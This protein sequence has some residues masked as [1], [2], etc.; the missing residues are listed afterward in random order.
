MY[1]VFVCIFLLAS[2]TRFAIAETLLNHEILN[3]YV[4]TDSPKNWFSYISALLHNYLKF[5]LAQQ[6]KGQK[7]SYFTKSVKKLMNRI[8][9]IRMLS[10]TTQITTTQYK[11]FSSATVII[12]LGRAM[13]QDF[14]DILHDGSN[15]CFK[16]GFDEY[17][18]HIHTWIFALDRQ[19][20]LNIT[21]THIR[22]VIS[23]L[24]TCYIGNVTVGTFDPSKNSKFKFVYCGILSNIPNYP[25]MRN[26]DIMVSIR[27]YVQ[28]IVVFSYGVIDPDRT[29][30]L[31]PQIDK[32]INPQ[33][34]LH[35]PTAKKYLQFV[36]L[37]VEKYNVI[38]LSF[39]KFIHSLY[40]VFDGPGR[41]SEALKLGSQTK[42]VTSTFQCVIFL[43]GS[44]NRLDSKPNVNVF[45]YLKTSNK[46]MEERFLPRNMTLRLSNT[47]ACDTDDKVCVF[48]LSTESEFQFNISIVNL[49]HTYTKRH[50]VYLWWFSSL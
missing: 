46:K 13:K 31:R 43:I 6:S 39:E 16:G 24:D 10:S 14:S 27:P 4:H 38:V 36:H 2:V 5:S 37:K 35:F 33:W 11:C 42:H 47:Q 40:E 9:I 19:L 29:I 1:F 25:K 8:K 21:F 7:N 23:H 30:S 20:R 41:R 34:F 50:H 45:Q 49:S 44:V 26:V 3:L 12:P 32:A 28:Y 15:P 18:F 17:Y 22:I 48:E